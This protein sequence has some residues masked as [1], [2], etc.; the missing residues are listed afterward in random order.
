MIGPRSALFTPFS[1]LGYIIIDEEHE[2]TYK[3]ETIPRYHARETAIE[4]ARM[5][6]ATVILGSATPSIESFY[7]AKKGDYLLLSMDKRVKEKPLPECEIVDLREE[8]KARNFSILSR[9]LH[10]K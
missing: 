10:K 4:R 3:S 5:S 8:L 9:S 2:G 6:G 7:H 1:N